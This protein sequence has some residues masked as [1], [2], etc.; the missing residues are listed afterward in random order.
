MIRRYLISNIVATAVLY[1][2]FHAMT[3]VLAAHV[4]QV[5]SGVLSATTD[6]PLLG[7]LFERLFQLTN[8]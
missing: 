2:A 4:D 5:L 1:A 8:I 6:S 7:P 3:P